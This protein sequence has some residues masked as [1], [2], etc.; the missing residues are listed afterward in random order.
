MSVNGVEFQVDSNSSSV[1]RRASR[2]PPTTFNY[3]EHGHR[4]H[5]RQFNSIRQ[6]TSKP[7]LTFNDIYLGASG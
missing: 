6:R 5:S 1:N 2:E 4:Q 3:T 7:H